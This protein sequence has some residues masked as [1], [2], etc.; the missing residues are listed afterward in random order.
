[1][2]TAKQNEIVEFVRRGHRVLI[3]SQEGEG[4]STVVNTIREDCFRWGLQVDIAC[5][6]GKARHVHQNGT[7]STVHCY[8]GLGAA[9]RPSEQVIQ[10]AVAR[11]CEKLQKLDVLIWDEGSISSGRVNAIHHHLV[12]EDYLKNFHLTKDRHFHEVFLIQL[13]LT[14]HLKLT[15]TKCLWVWGPWY[16]LCALSPQTYSWRKWN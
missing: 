9:D 12:K 8:Y 10:Y 15:Y 11:D 4:K 14:F 13:K 16:A 7:A 2:F 1:M 6:S 5:S 3:S